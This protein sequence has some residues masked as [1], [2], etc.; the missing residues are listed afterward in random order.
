VYLATMVVLISAMLH[1]ATPPRVAQL[2]QLLGVSRR[3]VARWPE[4][5]RTAFA[6]SRFWQAARAA[7]MP[8]VDQDRLPASLLERFAGGDAERL[9]ALLRFLAPITGGAIHAS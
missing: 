8:P 5:W 9:L 3:T 2:S 4:W 6:Q 7:F 1:G